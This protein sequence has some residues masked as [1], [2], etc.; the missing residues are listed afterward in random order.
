MNTYIIVASA[1]DYFIEEGCLRRRRKFARRELAI[2]FG[3]KHFDRGEAFYV[4]LVGQRAEPQIGTAVLDKLLDALDESRIANVTNTQRQVFVEYLQDTDVDLRSR[5]AV[6][7][8][9]TL[10]YVLNCALSEWVRHNEIEVYHTV[11]D[12]TAHVAP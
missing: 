6:V 10:R 1:S 8:K 5:T 2:E 11:E 3:E 7:Q 9:E 4:G 12:I